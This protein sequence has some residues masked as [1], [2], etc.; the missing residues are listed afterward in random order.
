MK[1]NHKTCVIIIS[2][3]DGT[4]TDS[5][6][7]N[8]IRNSK[9]EYDL[10][11]VETGSDI[12]KMSKYV[13]LWVK[14]KIRMT[15]GFNKG[16]QHALWREKWENVHYDNFWCL[17]NDA[18][19]P[20]QDV[21]SGL[22]EVMSCN[23]DCGQAHP[24][25]SNSVSP[26]QRGKGGNGWFKTSFVEIVCPMFSRKSIEIG[27]FDDRFF[28][29]WGLDYEIPYILHKN[30]LRSYISNKV[31]VFHTPSTTVNRNN[32]TEIKSQHHQF[33]V[34]RN[35]MM[36]VLHEKYGDKWGK[37][38]LD[39]IPSDVPSESFVHWATHIGCNYRF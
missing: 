23:N 13:T 15:R 8:I 18:K 17:V 37:T 22:L 14:D 35:N 21:M 16:I 26:Y 9:S 25:I 4:L 6:C 36:A 39:A 24:Y 28:Y 3:N 30:G 33:D 32:D 10:F 7:D 11:V 31:S 1:M 38:F 27:L 2:H 34:S 19:L 12:S 20:E 5:L 29:G